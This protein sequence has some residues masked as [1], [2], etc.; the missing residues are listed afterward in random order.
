[1]DKEKIKDKFGIIGTFANEAKI[2]V[3]NS[4]EVYD[5]CGIISKFKEINT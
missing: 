2:D 4:L 5:K 1:M 3:K